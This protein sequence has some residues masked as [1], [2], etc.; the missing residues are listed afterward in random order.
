MFARNFLPVILAVNLMIFDLSKIVESRSHPA[1]R[2]SR[3]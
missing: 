1:R 2:Y 3:K